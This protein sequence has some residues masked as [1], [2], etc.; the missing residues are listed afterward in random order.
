MYIR[1]RVYVYVCVQALKSSL[2]MRVS[3]INCIKEERLGRLSE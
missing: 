3:S 2:T 1:V